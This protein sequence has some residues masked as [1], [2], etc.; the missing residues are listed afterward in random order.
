MFLPI[1]QQFYMMSNKGIA[2]PVVSV[3]YNA[4]PPP[5]YNCNLL[6]ANVLRGLF[7]ANVLMLLLCLLVRHFCCMSFAEGRY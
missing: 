3:M 6:V 4:S 2:H 1:Q 7:C 5:V